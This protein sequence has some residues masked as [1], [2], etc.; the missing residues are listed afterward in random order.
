[1][2]REDLRLIR[3]R[4]LIS[5]NAVGNL[6]VI[7]CKDADAPHKQSLAKTPALLQ[8]LRHGKPL[9]RGLRRMDDPSALAS[10]LYGKPAGASQ[11]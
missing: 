3:A 10:A 11:Q 8:Q 7:P 5:M 9:P 2:P 6:N 4:A 1:M